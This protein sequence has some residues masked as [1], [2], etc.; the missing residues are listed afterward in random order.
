MKASKMDTPLKYI[1][2]SLAGTSDA[3]E[4]D[5]SLYLYALKN[6]CLSKLLLRTSKPSYCRSKAFSINIKGNS[7][8]LYK[9]VNIFN[10]VKS[11]SVIDFTER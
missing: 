4:T 7:L 8:T 6:N 3:P 10:Q 11:N 2:N 5:F 9:L 1:K